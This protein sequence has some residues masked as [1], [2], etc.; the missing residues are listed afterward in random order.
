MSIDV[1]PAPTTAPV[2]PRADE[3]VGRRTF[4]VMLA[5]AV[6]IGVAGGLL[7][8]EEMVTDMAVVAEG[9]AVPATVVDVT[10]RVRDD[11][12]RVVA[13]DRRMALRAPGAHLRIGDE[14]DV[15]VAEARRSPVALG[16]EAHSSGWRTQAV[17][18]WPAAVGAGA[19]FAFGSLCVLGPLVQLA[20][21]PFRRRRA[22]AAR[23]SA[24]P[25]A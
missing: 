9:E 24:V 8:D 4:R 12:V 21:L 15:V 11:E 2:P 14:L 25:G 5:V 22:A 7:C 23:R 17:L 1:A 18:R 19:V 10:Y 20:T 13:G 6:V 3:G 16:V